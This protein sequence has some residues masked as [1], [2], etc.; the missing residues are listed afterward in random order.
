M[1]QWSNGDESSTHGFPRSLSL[2]SDSEEEDDVFEPVSYEIKSPS[3][4]KI[5]GLRVFKEVDHRNAFQTNRRGCPASTSNAIQTEN[6]PENMFHK[7]IFLLH[8]L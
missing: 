4:S 1:D 2:L 6:Q 8:I 3:Q 7:V 5:P